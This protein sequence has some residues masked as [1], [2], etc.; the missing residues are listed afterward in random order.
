MG[1]ISLLGPLLVD[2][3]QALEPRDRIALS[4]LV[5]RR[6]Q[7]VPPGQFADALWGE[8][9]PLS[10]SKQVQICVARLRKVLG[11][12]AIETVPGG[13]RLALDSGDLD[14]DKFEQIIER[15]RA[16]AATGEADRA[17]SAY[18]RALSLWRGRPLEELDGWLP[19]R[20]EAARLE[21][22]RRSVDEDLL[23]ARLA[24][25]E[26]RAV[27]VE[28]EALVNDEPL[29]ER[30]WVILALAQ[31]RCGRQ[32]DALKTLG[33]ARRR[34]MEEL[35]IDPGPDLVA[36]QRAILQQDPALNPPAEPPSVSESCPYKGLASYE[37]GD[38]EIFF[39]RDAEIV[40][41]LDRLRST[42]LLVVAG[43]SG[44]GKSSLVRAGIV[45][46]LRKGGRTTVV[47]VPGEDPDAAMADALASVHGNA[48]LVIDQFEELFAL[49]IEVVRAFCRRIAA[50]ARDQAPV[51]IAGRSDRLGGLGAEAAFSRLAEQGLYLVNPLV[52]DAL[53]EVIEQ[54]ATHAGLRLEQGL[55][56]LLVRDCDGE[57]GALP[58]LSHALVETW[59]R[60]D[61]HV[62]TV[63]GYRAT[64][65]IRGA[66]ARSADRLYDSLPPEQRAT[67]RSVL[68]RLVAPSLDGDPVRCRVPTR[69]LLGDPGR[70]RVVAVLVRSRLVTS[71]QDTIALAH[72][73]LA[74]AWPRLQTWLDEDAAGQRIL[75]HL[76]TAAD[77]W[78]SL[79]RP[80][81]E[82]Y[83]GARLDTALEWQEAT[84]PDL[85]DLERAFLD[86]STGRSASES[87]AL[88]ERARRNARHNRRL[89]GLL[90]ATAILLVGSLAAGLLAIRGAEDARQQRDIARDAR[91]T[92]ELEALV[93]QSL[94]LRSTDR[95]VAALLAVEAYRRWPD[96]R[97]WA[98]LLGTFTAAPNF[99]GYQYLPASRLSGA[100]VPDTST[101]V[102]A[103]D[104]RDL[105]LRDVASGTLVSRFPLA[106]ADALGPSVVRVSGDG[107]FVAQFIRTAGSEDCADPDSQP[108]GCGALSVYEIATGRRV[109]GPI[110]PPFGLGDIAINADGSLVAVAGGPDG[111]LAVYRR[112]DGELLGT[113]TGLGRPDDIYPTDVPHLDRG[114]AAVVFGPD[115]LLYL[116]SMTGLIRVVDPT[117]LGIVHTFDVPLMSSHNHLVTTPEGLLIGAGSYAIVAIEIGTGATRWTANLRTGTHPEPCPW[118]AAAATVGRLYCGN[119]YGVIEER[120]LATGQRTGITHDAQLGSVGDLSVAMDGRELLAFGDEAPVISRWRLD[121][122]GLVT[123]LVAEGH[124][125]YDGYDPSGETILV[126]LRDPTATID[127]DF[128]DF[129]LWDPITDE[130]LG[131]F[132]DVLGP[133]WAGHGTIVGFSLTAGRVSFF[134]TAPIALADGVTIP[135]NS[136]HQWPSAG[137]ERVYV[138]FE[139]GEIWTVDVVTRQRIEPTLRVDGMP[140]YVSATRHGERIV[141][142]TAGASDHVTTVHDGHTGQQ[143]GEPL[144]GPQV[145]SVSLDGVLIGANSGDITRYDLETLKPV[146]NFPGARGEVNT[147]QFSRD[148]SVFLATSNDQTVSIY[149]IASG[150]RIGDP[151]TT[152]APFIYPGWLRP[153][154]K[155]V[156]VTA[157]EGVTVWDI[158]PAH[159]AEAACQLAG[160]NLTQTEW[161]TYLESPGNYP[162]TC[163]RL[164]TP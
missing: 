57:P 121:G 94:A 10:W 35:G 54:P 149:D 98:A 91:A 21:E 119:F 51:V 28:A 105:E 108:A 44:C 46:A 117:T 97:A 25:G 61:G 79:G 110:T 75:R 41:C 16:L 68:L 43:P 161:N 63:E 132:S 71:E 84:K 17:A 139:S 42:P 106:E 55:V 150:V 137:G 72:E 24:A 31:Y 115:G 67:L 66:V 70:E 104:G 32:A 83:R 151:I 58:L 59:R 49:G 154:G 88:A 153:D 99:L 128:R 142:T 23:D 50:Y 3:G 152:A 85:T 76:S 34:L 38:E 29:R 81:S 47:M 64:G 92:A 122:S 39:G 164:L 33:L 93:N 140:W 73:A 86:A 36:L 20:S 163:P 159:L 107:R 1:G 2:G 113:L 89:R 155:A 56:D 9:P 141:V 13:Y 111:D 156:A 124:V 103:L 87:R 133:G 109:L 131:T 15:A 126:A 74:R 4:V 118:L 40:A 65:G 147:L 114:T 158:D 18:M 22:L 6:G 8:D 19:G 60:R 48:V 30:R 120:D 53:R 69:N 136:H 160:R 145:T 77:G 112:S 14:I 100:M 5:V 135:L 123:D 27:A 37:A 125:A 138:G 116:G 62:L 162:A 7:V 78:D 157:R 127:H 148:D 11:S 102:V 129:A 101:A 45:P 80:D 143:I 96:A 52:G 12:S 26:H 82:L 144:L 90:A 130:S 95:G 134:D 146:A